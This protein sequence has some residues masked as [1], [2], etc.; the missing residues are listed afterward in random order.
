MPELPEV[1]T[2]CRQLQQV[3]TGRMISDL[4]VHDLRLGLIESPAGQKIL[5]VSRWGKGLEMTLSDGRSFGLHLRMTGRLLWHKSD[6]PLLPHTRFTLSFGSEKIICIDP[7]RF[8]TLALRETP[9]S[10]AP[11]LPDPLRGLE[12]GCLCEIARKRR[13]PVKAFLMDQRVIAGIGNIYACE[14]L[15]RA[16]I[17]PLREVCSLSPDNWGEVA[18]ATAAVLTRAVECRGTTVSDWRDLFGQ[19]G[20]FQHELAAYAR[21]GQPCLRCGGII[22]RRRLS[23]RGTWFCTSCQR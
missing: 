12:I 10:N 21:E 22:I 6:L 7:R 5:N 11:P 9:T 16:A 8:A 20:A 1:E 15:Y 19:P 3:I 17:N 14:I 18:K 13:L 2:L 4:V 23:G